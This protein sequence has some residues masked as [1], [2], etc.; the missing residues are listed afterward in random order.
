MNKHQVFLILHSELQQTSL[1]HFELP[2]AISA[3]ADMFAEMKSAEYLISGCNLWPVLSKYY[4]S[5]LC[6]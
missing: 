1:R 4:D 2:P 3:N 6:L 5:K